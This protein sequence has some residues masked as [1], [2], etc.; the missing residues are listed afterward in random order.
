[1]NVN[2]T[3]PRKTSGEKPIGGTARSRRTGSA[4]DTPLGSG[5]PRPS[6]AIELSAEAQDFLRVRSRLDAVAPP[7]REQRIA[8]L[9]GLVARGAYRV[10]GEGI[11]DAMLRDEGTASMLGLPPA[12]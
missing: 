5:G 2:P 12:R 11:A 1:M 6:G 4:A 7:S 3:D 10:D 8:E 9:A